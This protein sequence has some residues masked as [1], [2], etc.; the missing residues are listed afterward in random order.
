L[1]ITE[2]DRQGMYPEAYAPYRERPVERQ[3]AA[4]LNV[5]YEQSHVDQDVGARGDVEALE[6]LDARMRSV[7]AL[8]LLI[9]LSL[10]SRSF[11]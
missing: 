10:S 1:R 11:Y 4:D 5:G 9:H 3:S 6:G 8:L 7:V 2:P